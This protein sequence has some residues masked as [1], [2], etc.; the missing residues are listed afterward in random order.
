MEQ[1]IAWDKQLTVFINSF[2]SPSLDGMMLMMTKT[3]FWVPLY[4]LILYLI[5]KK[6]EPY[7]WH[8]VIGAV[9]TIA[10]SDQI[11]SS[12]LKPLF[13]RLRPSHDP[14]LESLIH[15]V[16]IND[17]EVYQGGLYGFASSHAANSFGAALFVFLLFKRNIYASFLFIWAAFF[18]YTRIYLGVHFI[19]DILAGIVI[20][21]AAAYAGYRLSLLLIS[22]GQRIV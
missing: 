18:S 6:Q 8:W 10:L 4:F 20:G 19:G 17:R 21:F 15:L 5:Y 13:E 9:V 16:K 14:S 11:T 12:I 1:F 2:H 22:K 7:F 3:S